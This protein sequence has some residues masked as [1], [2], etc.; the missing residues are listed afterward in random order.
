MPW[1]KPWAEKG[2]PKNL[3]S[4]KEYQGINCFLLHMAPHASPYFLTY[5]QAQDRGGNV[6]KDE[7]GYPVVYW[8]MLQIPQQKNDHR[9]LDEK[10]IPF[11]R[12]YTVF[13]VEQ[14]DGIEYPQPENRINFNP[15]AKCEKI[16]ADMSNPPLITHDEHAAFYR[17]S[18]DRVNMP[19][20]ATFESVEKYYA[21][22]FHE[23]THSTGHKNR[24]DRKGIT[25]QITFGSM[26]YS[27]EELIGEMGAA[28]LC[29]YSGIENVTIDNSAAYIQ[30]WLAK[31]E[32]DKQLVISA[33]AQ[34]QKAVNYIMN[35]KEDNLL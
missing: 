33:A 20:Q 10:V 4:G 31:L 28:F 12:Y 2:F 26:N 29:G 35:R 17:P 5:K 7:H 32:N 30:G 34:A 8:K 11:M 13:N 23:L 25:E 9:N 1:K 19:R 6:R 24:L 15:I 14:C 16:V 18:E 21:A 27:K 22:L 3:V